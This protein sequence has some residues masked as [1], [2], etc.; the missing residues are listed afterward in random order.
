MP[1]I[2]VYMT[3]ETVKRLIECSRMDLQKRSIAD[4]AS[5]AVE[6]VARQATRGLPD[7]LFK[8]DES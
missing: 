5:A 7:K 4:L 8:G 3:E 2:E 1:L 6:E